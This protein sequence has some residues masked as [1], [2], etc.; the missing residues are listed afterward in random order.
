MGSVN[1]VVIVESAR[2]L[3]KHGDKTLNQFHAP[4]I[5]AV[6]AALGGL[7]LPIYPRWLR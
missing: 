2:D 7:S 1:F 5:V 3:L 6:A 4:S